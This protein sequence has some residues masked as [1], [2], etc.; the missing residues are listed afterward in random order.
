MANQA[1]RL[2]TQAQDHNGMLLAL[3]TCAGSLLSASRFQAVLDLLL[4]P[5]ATWEAADA[6]G[7]PEGAP[8]N[9]EV[10]P[11]CY[12]F[13]SQAALHLKQL[14]LASQ[15]MASALQAGDLPNDT[16]VATAQQNMGAILNRQGA[17]ATCLDV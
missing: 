11:L 2:Y 7:E 1:I 10:L 8:D 3:V 9:K 15:L 4:T 14:E 6:N 5:L 12:A 13:A 16:S 17:P